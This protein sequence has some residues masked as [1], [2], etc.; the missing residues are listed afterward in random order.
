M[1]VLSAVQAPQL[2]SVALTSFKN[3]LFELALQYDQQVCTQKCS[4]HWAIERCFTIVISER[5]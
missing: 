2:T 4:L 1:Y 5:D 3:V